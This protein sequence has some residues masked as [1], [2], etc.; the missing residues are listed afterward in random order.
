MDKKPR[1]SDFVLK[2]INLT[3]MA[4]AVINKGSFEEKKDEMNL[5]NL[6]FGMYNR[7]IYIIVILLYIN[8]Q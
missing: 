2:T 6:F 4:S 3:L 7:I 1:L 8:F 5:L